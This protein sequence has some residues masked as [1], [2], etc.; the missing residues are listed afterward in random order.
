MID[1]WYGSMVSRMSGERTSDVSLVSQKSPL[2]G[3]SLTVVLSE[4]VCMHGYVVSTEYKYSKVYRCT[5]YTRGVGSASKGHS[6]RFI[7]QVSLD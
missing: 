7:L 3:E 4:V 2:M 6:S 5:N 1:L